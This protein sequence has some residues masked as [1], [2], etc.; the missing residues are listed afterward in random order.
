MTVATP[1]QTY[2]H[3]GIFEPEKIIEGLAREVNISLQQGYSAFRGTGELGWAA[4]LP[5]VLMRL[6][7][8]EALFDA[9][10]SPHFIALCQY[11]E[12]LFSPELISRIIRIH[13]KVVAR[14]Q[15]LENPYYLQPE[16]FLASDYPS[17]SLET[18]M[19]T[20]SFNR[21]AGMALAS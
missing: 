10:L 9:K 11:N 3:H 19:A 20:P 18:L 21:P 14:Q 13:P 16:K 5:S 8:Y 2:L 15:L 12:T 1:E 17:T 6:Y 4:S 7:E